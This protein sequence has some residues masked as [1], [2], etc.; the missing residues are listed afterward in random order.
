MNFSII[1]RPE[2]VAH[3]IGQR[4]KEI[5]IGHRYTQSELAARA[6]ISKRSVERLENGDGDPRL[7]AF[8]AVCAALGLTDGF[9]RLLPEVELSR[10]QILAAAPLPKRVRQK[11]KKT[12]K[13]GNEE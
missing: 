5:R 6:G 1:D 4:L 11:K 9:N 8:I 13:W 7:S 12:V 2:V 3:K 10:N